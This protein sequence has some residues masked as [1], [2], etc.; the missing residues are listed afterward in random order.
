MKNLTNRQKEVLEFIARFTD[1]NGYPPTVREI[2]DHFD[3][4][5]RAVQDHIAACQKKGYLSQCQK[6]SR[7]IRVLKNEEGVSETKAFTSRIPLLGTVAAG[8]PLLSEEN[9]DGYVTIAEPFVRPGKTYFAL[10]VRGS[11]MINAGILEGDLAIIEKADVASEGQI[12]VA[13]VDNAITLKRFYRE[14]NRIRLQPE[15]PDFQPIYTN[16]AHLAGIMVGLVRTY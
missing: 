13:V 5:L 2:G 14:E 10:R 8:K 6:R 12:V 11:S 3:I 4:S 16:D 9:V 7:S 15:N 1:E